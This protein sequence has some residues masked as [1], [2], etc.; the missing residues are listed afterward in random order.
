MKKFLSL[1]LAL[2]MT[3]SL[4]TI[5]AGAKDFTDGDKI[6]YKEAIDVVSAIGV[7]DG[8]ADGSFNPQATLTRGAAAKIICNLIL[9]PTTAASLSADAAPFKDVPADNNFAGYIAYCS[10][11]GIINGYA[12]GTF[13][14][15]N[16]LTGYAF[17]K[18]LLGALGYDA[19]IEGFVGNNWSIQVAKTALGIGLDKGMVDSFNGLKAVTREEACLFAFNTLK[20]TLVDYDAKTTVSVGGAEVTIGSSKAKPVTVA[21]NN[22]QTGDKYDGNID[23]DGFVQFAE[24]YFTKLVKEGERDAFM[25]PSHV[26]TLKG[27]KIGSYVDTPDATYVGKVK[28]ADI[29]DDVKLTSTTDDFVVYIDGVLAEN[30]DNDFDGTAGRAG[31]PKDASTITVAKGDTDTKV[32]TGKGCVV[33]V[34]KSDKKDV[35]GTIVVLNTYV[36]KVIG[37]EKASGKTKASTDV[38]PVGPNTLDS[39]KNDTAVTVLD[40][41]AFESEAFS[42]E[43]IITF[44][45][46]LKNAYKAD[47]VTAST[48]K[49]EIKN[50]A[51]AETVQGTVNSIGTNSKFTLDGTTYEYGE[52]AAAKLA[53]SDVST[54]ANVYLDANGYALYFDEGEDNLKN[55]ALVLSAGTEVSYGRT[56]YGVELLLTNGTVKTGKSDKDYTDTTGAALENEWVTYKTNSKG[57]LVLTQ[58]SGATELTAAVASQSAI[59]NN[60]SKNNLKWSNT[61]STLIN[62]D[63]LIIVENAAGKFKV[64]NGV[65]E[66]PTIEKE[67]SLGTDA[68]IKY[69]VYQ[70]STDTYAKLVYIVTNGPVEESSNK[71]IFLKSDKGADFWDDGNNSYYVFDAVVDG[72]LVEDG[73]MVDYTDGATKTAVDTILASTKNVGV[74]LSTYAVD[75]NIYTIDLS[76]TTRISSSNNGGSLTSVEKVTGTSITF[77]DG[78][79][80]LADDC[81]FY[82]VNT[83]GDLEETTRS[84][85]RTGDTT[86]VNA[87]YNYLAYSLN[88]D[89]EITGVYWTIKK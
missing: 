57:E 53:P 26:W 69:S 72:K 60:T 33:E 61:A 64:Y 84:A 16:T 7:V 85:L 71:T 49:G 67:V 32:G 55:Y 8:Y 83:H 77:S 38:A 21:N 15:G 39:Y 87:Y 22:V 46:S 47:L 3:M 45:Y 76:K 42:V 70:K 23:R 59:G 43:D 12:D 34:F 9:G 37:V 11:A 2:V 27:D 14:P 89:M 52:K 13:K 50:A 79:F 36:G 62:S 31:A 40:N 66:M 74:L 63:T 18:M 88:S 75:N 51:K 80:T 24:Q 82:R 58:L 10:K 48:G 65:K 41:D 4:V 20:S 1:V 54:T 56:S 6:N 68:T 29:Y 30:Y 19:A 28:F 78:T 44:N 35:P 25:R 17:M 73:I 81:V 86:S 5:S